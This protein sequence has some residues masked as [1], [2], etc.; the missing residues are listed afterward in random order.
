VR[1]IS[2]LATF[3]FGLV[4]V[5]GLVA[6]G[7]DWAR[8]EEASSQLDVGRRLVRKLS[9]MAGS[10][11]SPG[12]YRIAFTGDST[13]VSYPQGLQLPQL[14]A[15][16]ANRHSGGW[17]ALRVYSIAHQGTG[18]FD[19]YYLTDEFIAA[20]PDLVII[21]FNLASLS[22]R[23]G[24]AF[25]RPEL[26]GWMSADRLV[27]TLTL[28]VGSAGLTVDQALLYF[29]LVHGGASD[30]WFWLDQLQLRVGQ[31]REGV[32]RWVA[33]KNRSG[34][35][36]EKR[37][38]RRQQLANWA[39]TS[40][41]GELR[42]NAL[43]MREQYGRALA[44]VDE[45][46]AQLR[47]LRATLGRLREAGIESLVYVVPV[48]HEH[49]ERL[50][51]AN[52]AGLARTLG[53]IESTVRGQGAHFADLHALLPDALFRDAAGHF[54]HESENGPRWVTEALAPSV[55]AAARGAVGK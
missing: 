13:V 16:S 48:N 51:L 52:E 31:A 44:G 42:Y 3:V 30:A 14:L 35:S 50:G 2:F 9:G 37:F 29:A 34:V 11:G 15:E 41:P 38:E 54:V 39:R 4:C 5:L 23:W 43:G 40:L 28:P 7:L 49:I 36:A 1:I 24:R 27:E 55:V 22:P 18:V 20:H 8:L 47:V 6:S 25:S 45:R 12:Q 46:N 26:S 17:L 53:A 33:A 10:F 21:P 19:Y 32:E